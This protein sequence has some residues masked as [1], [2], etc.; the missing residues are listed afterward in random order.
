MAVASPEAPWQGALTA[1]VAALRRVATYQLPV[2]LDRRI[3][4]LGERKDSLTPEE[5]EELM[6]WVA[7][8]QELSVEK[9]AAELA[10]Q[11]ATAVSLDYES[12]P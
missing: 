1:S 6:A 10:L 9:L 12:A 4:N 7:F 2:A 8:T 11:R 5:R 3:L